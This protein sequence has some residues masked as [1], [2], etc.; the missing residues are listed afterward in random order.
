MRHREFNIFLIILLNIIS[1]AVLISCSN[2]NRTPQKNPSN[3]QAPALTSVPEKDPETT[4]PV[5]TGNTAQVDDVPGRIHPSPPAEPSL[6][7]VRIP[8]SEAMEREETNLPYYREENAERYAKYREENP[9][10]AFQQVVVYVNIGLDREFYEGIKPAV[11]IDSLSVLVNKFYK[12]P[13]DFKPELTKLPD[14]LCVQDAGEQ[15]LRKDAAE[16]LLKM[17]EDAKKEGLNILVYG[18]YRSISTQNTIWNNAINSGRTQEDVDSLNARGGHSEHHTGLA[19]DVIKNNYSVAD[20]PEYEW[21]KDKAHEYGFIIRYPKGKEHI[22]GYK[23]EPWHL[24]YV[25]PEI[26]AAVYESGLTYEEYY[27]TIIDL[28]RGQVPW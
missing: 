12:L 9:D 3:T 7:A 26:A 10:M 18:T 25:G 2:S 11:N 17:S 19:V 16:A 5:K 14:S 28:P 23:Y 27:V 1:V 20:T 13:D 6:S 8:G 15:F 24:R 21:Y 4:E 22:T